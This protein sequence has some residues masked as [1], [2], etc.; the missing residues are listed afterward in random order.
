MP[1]FT[2]LCW[3]RC[4]LVRC[5]LLQTDIVWHCVLQESA[6]HHRS[7]MPVSQR[8]LLISMTAQQQDCAQ[9]RLV[10][11]QHPKLQDQ[12]A[13]QAMVRS[14][15]CQATT[16]LGSA[17]MHHSFALLSKWLLPSDQRFFTDLLPLV[18]ML[19]Y[20][21]QITRLHTS[22]SGLLSSAFLFVVSC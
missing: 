6:H 12:R 18:H 5:N 1:C 9:Q 22:G 14:T 19:P 4:Q 7:A 8:L 17:C 15:L 11:V 3:H 16:C 20:K 13:L 21:L 10:S 2:A